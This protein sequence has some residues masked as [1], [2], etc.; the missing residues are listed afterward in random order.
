[1]ISCIVSV[2]NCKLFKLDTL[3][4]RQL[5]GVVDGASGSTHVLLPSIGAGLATSASGLFTSKSTADFSSRSGN[6][7]IDNTTV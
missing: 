1:M 2:A 5:F 4:Q 6:V 3:S 7:D